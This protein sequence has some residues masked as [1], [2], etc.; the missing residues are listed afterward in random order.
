MPNRIIKD[1]IRTSAD[2]DCLSWFEEVFYY[3][4]I[5]T[6]DDYGCFDGRLRILNAALFPL[7]DLTDKDIDNALNKLES[8]GMLRRY[9]VN[10]EPFLHILAWED[11][12]Q[13]R[14]KKRKFPD[15]EDADTVNDCEE[16]KSIEINCNQLK[17]N[18]SPIQSNPILSESLSESLSNQNPSTAPGGA[19]PSVSDYQQDRFDQ[20]WSSYPKK[21][22][23]QA[24]LKAWK[25]LRPN[26]D[27]HSKIMVAVE[28]Q[29]K[30]EQWKTENGRYI[31]NPTTWLNQGRWDDE[32]PKGNGRP[33]LNS[34]TGVIGDNRYFEDDQPKYSW[35]ATI[36][37]YQEMTRKHE[38]EEARAKTNNQ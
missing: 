13:V 15:P 6:V 14:N 4:L 2:I 25:K 5:V 33:A 24:A 1:K 26:K 28:S 32:L 11:H 17:S 16:L 27:L 37:H 35:D 23:K 29:K 38:E 18:D 19:G 7:K 31:P 12:Q 3:R 8:V 21:V 10:G 34:K 36:K 9:T 22:G 30:S 20:F